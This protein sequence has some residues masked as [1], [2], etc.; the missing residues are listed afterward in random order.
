MGGWY[1]LAIAWLVHRPREVAADRGQSQVI[2]AILIFGFVI[3]GLGLYQ[4]TV[5]PQQTSEVE[6]QHSSTVKD[7]F[8][9]VHGAIVDAGSA[10]DVRA[11]SV[12]LGTRYPPRALTLNPSPV[13]GRVAIDDLP[14]P[15]GISAS[16]DAGA[17]CG[18]S[19]SAPKTLTYKA[20]YNR[21]SNAGSHGYETSVTYHSVNEK[22]TDSDQALVQGTTIRLLPL[23]E[24]SL[25][26]SGINSKTLEFEGGTT[27]GTTLTSAAPTITLP[28]ELSKSQWKTILE[29][30]EKVDTITKPSSNRV[31]ISFK[32]DTYTVRCTPIGEG[33]TPSNSPTMLPGTNGGGGSSG[34]SFNPAGAGTLVYESAA[35]DGSNGVD[36]T[37][38]NTDTTQRTISDIRVPFY[39]S[40]GQGSSGGA[41]AEVV[42]F[43][44]G[45]EEDTGGP[46]RSSGFSVGPGKTNT[47]DI[48]FFCRSTSSTGPPS[49]TPTTTSSNYEIGSGDYFVISVIFDNGETAKYFINPPSSN[50][51]NGNG[52]CA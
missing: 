31:R 51:G 30:A 6:L 8:A 1:E 21:F 26:E 15:T 49:S 5:V 3:A 33:A 2:G 36:I 44:S 12:K 27:G 10:N 11:A 47:Y 20:D 25:S 19:L 17:V 45:S 38:R 16:F 52:D 41:A 24:G 42:E 50:S 29:G 22:I 46:Y 43:D 28:T 37:F 13:Y 23:V 32:T 34:T 48:A 9:G 14:G 39:D 18:P 35:M 4:V 40:D 7:D